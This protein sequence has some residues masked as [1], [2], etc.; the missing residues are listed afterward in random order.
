M[1]LAAGTPSLLCTVLVRVDGALLCRGLSRA[2]MPR[3]CADDLLA[4]ALPAGT[5]L[6]AGRA[7]LERE[8][9]R[10]VLM[11]TRAPAFPRFS[12]GELALLSTAMLRLLDEP[13]PLERVL[14]AL[15]QQGAAA[16]AVQGE[17]TPQALATAEALGLPLLVLPPG[18]P[19]ADIERGAARALSDARAQAYQRSRALFQELLACATSRA[20]LPGVLAR[21]AVLAGSP[22]VLEDHTP[23]RLRHVALPAEDAALPPDLQ[24]D[25]EAA[26]V[27]RQPELVAA[28]STGGLDAADPPVVRQRLTGI[29][30]PWPARAAAPVVLDGALTGFFSVLSTLDT[31]GLEVRLLAAAGAAVCAVMLAQERAVLSTEERLQAKLLENLLAGPRLARAVL[32]SSATRLGLDPD[33]P[34][35]PVAIRVHDGADPADAL[36][37]VRRALEGAGLR[38]PAVSQGDTVIA[39]LPAPGICDD[40]SAAALAERLRRVV[41]LEAGRPVSA[42]VSHPATPAALAR[43]HREALE[44]LELGISV[45]GT[46]R[47]VGYRQ[48]ALYRLLRAV[49]D[50]MELQRF[51]LETLGPLHEYDARV[52][53]QLVRTLAVF[54]ECG[55]SPTA[56]AARLEMHRN[57]LLYRLERIRALTGYDLNAPETRLTLEV[58]LRIRRLLD[59]EAA[60]DGPVA[61]HQPPHPWRNGTM[62]GDMPGE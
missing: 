59:A 9:T 22:V 58:A 30:L 35:L 55:Y 61:F 4:L 56:A 43:C 24:A 52:G 51:Y 36:Q 26:L 15:R 32:R 7:G 29:G 47:T 62:Q 48:L 1:R 3:L 40:R 50:R 25:L 54:I 42:G 60:G 23:P 16:V 38:G 21:A 17:V 5:R 18:Q 14:V 19:L 8:V 11:R 46:G 45:L 2:L 27:H 13:L 34:A 31:A 53:A 41:A 10:P 39:F 20:G 33:Q 49:P 57:G 37:A 28:L 44:A 6:V 12:G